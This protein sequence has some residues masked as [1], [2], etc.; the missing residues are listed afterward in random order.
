VRVALTAGK[1]QMELRE[2]PEP[3]AGPGQ[4][5]LRVG[6]VGLCGGDI[7]IYRGEHPYA[8]YPL[9]QGHEFCGSVLS[10]GPGYEGPLRLGDLVAVEPLLPCGGCFA[11]RRGH[12]NCCVGL[13]VMG[14]HVGGALA[15]QVAVPVSSC[16]PVGDLPPE[17]AALVEPISIGLQAVV[18]SGATMGDQMLVLGAGPIGQAVTVCAVDRGAEV[19]VVDK[20]ENRLELATQ[21]GASLVTDVTRASV[22]EAV[23]AWTGGDGPA[24]VVDATGVPALIRLAAD[25]VAPSGTVVV[26]GI[27]L[28]AVALSVVDFTRKELNVLGSRNNAGLFADAVQIVQRSAD[29]VARL[30]THRFPFEEAPRAM[31]FLRDHPEQAEKVL[32]L[33]DERMRGEQA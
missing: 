8:T 7:H 11:C 12:P 29:R 28:N 25:V 22:D 4:V 21:L 24:I 6:V 17:L 10:F 13:K 33:V 1:G 14:A 31:E 16:Y 9:V 32:V 30:I 3:E 18:R 27:S 19:M 2:L 23:F 20:L 15:E 5:V 26:V